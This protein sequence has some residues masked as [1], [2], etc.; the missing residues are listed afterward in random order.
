MVAHL[1]TL[2]QAVTVA[3]WEVLL[4]KEAIVSPITMTS[5]NG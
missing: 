1:P 5:G 2:L 4:E 3:S